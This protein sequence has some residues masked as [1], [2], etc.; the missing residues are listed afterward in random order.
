MPQREQRNLDPSDK[1]ELVSKSHTDKLSGR[2]EHSGPS[3]DQQSWWSKAGKRE[4]KVK[5]G[6]NKKREKLCNKKEIRI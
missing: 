5:M 6:K 1:L 4:I 2:R 3:N